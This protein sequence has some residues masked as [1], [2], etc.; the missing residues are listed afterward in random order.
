MLSPL[1]SSHRG[2][3]K[4]SRRAEAI[5][6]ALNSRRSGKGW[7]ARCPAHP[8]ITPSLSINE[9]P[10][11][12]VLV[13]CFAG[14]S[15][16]EVIAALRR[17]GLWPGRNRRMAIDATPVVQKDDTHR[18]AHSNE[19]SEI[20]LG[21]WRS[22]V[23]AE[24]TLAETYLASRGIFLPVPD[25]LRFNRALRHPSGGYW[26]AMMALVTHGVDGTPLAVLRTFL[27]RDG[28]GKA[29]VE[30]ERMM[31]GPCRG[32][33]ARLGDPG[34]VLL[35]GEGIET[36]LAA[37]QATGHPAWAALSTSGLKGLELPR[38]VRHVIVAA[39]GDAAG[40]AAACQCAHRWQ[41]EG[42]RVRIARPPRGTDFNDLMK[43]GTRDERR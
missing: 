35:V 42:R 30:P 43:R 14:C 7:M 26:P 31:L 3:G 36:C 11:R 20:A 37:M 2:L 22:S 33:V 39:D 27:A 1:G 16:A 29:P 18:L 28:S 38:E 40:E 8:D 24:G 6:E 41:R 19:C 5:A 9:T 15:Q 4:G 25:A 32:G 12:K 10:T 17:R 21:L 13:K 34:E 23:P